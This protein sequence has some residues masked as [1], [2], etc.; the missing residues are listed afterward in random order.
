MRQIE[1]KENNNKAENLIETNIEAAEEFIKNNFNKNSRGD[2]NIYK[3]IPIPEDILN[4]K[5]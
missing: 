4:E 5:N 1:G 3:S 2:K